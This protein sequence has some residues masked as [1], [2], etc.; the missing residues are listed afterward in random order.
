MNIKT[1]IR[2]GK[3]GSN[4]GGDGVSGRDPNKP[5]SSDDSPEV[6]VEVYVPPVSRCAGL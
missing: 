5:R 3:G 6:E 4:S 1:N 2:A